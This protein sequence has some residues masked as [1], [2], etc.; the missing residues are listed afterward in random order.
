MQEAFV[1]TLSRYP[2]FDG[3]KT[4]MGYLAT[5][6]YRAAFRRRRLPMRELPLELPE[7]IEHVDPDLDAP[8]MVR[9]VLSSLGPKQ[10][11][12]LLL[13]YLHDLDDDEIAAA[14]GCRPSTVR[15]QIAR[16]LANARQEVIDEPR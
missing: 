9:Q 7:R 10:R 2:A 6:L 14:L 16:G 3:L 12:C 5:V 13:R 1:E 8:L 15:S 11:A 4:P